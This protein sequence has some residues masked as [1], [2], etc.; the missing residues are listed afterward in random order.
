M[1]IEK[2]I[3]ASLFYVIGNSTP[4]IVIRDSRQKAHSCANGTQKTAIGSENLVISSRFVIFTI[5][6][7]NINTA[8]KVR[9]WHTWQER[10][11][12]CG[13]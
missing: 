7:S 8:E 3:E 11:Q 4:S 5:S 13:K 6:D 12:L 10:K 1:E 2:S 9:G